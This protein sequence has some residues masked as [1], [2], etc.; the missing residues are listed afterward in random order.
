[1][2]ISKPTALSS[3]PVLPSILRFPLRLFP[4]RLQSEL[5]VRALNR[6]FA[7]QLGDEELDFLDNKVLSLQVKDAGIC[8]NVSHSNQKLIVMPNSSADLV[9]AGNLYD[10]L[11]LASRREDPDTLFFNRHLQLI[12]DTELGLYVKNFLDSVDM[13]QWKLLSIMSHKASHLAERF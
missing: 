10:F 4:A 2:N 7:Q 8:V 13:E 11:L 5:F 9:I 12:G 3:S 1:M 6:L